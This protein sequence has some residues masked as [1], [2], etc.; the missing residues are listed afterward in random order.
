VPRIKS[1]KKSLRKSRELRLRNQATE[2]RVK[3]AVRAARAA[4]DTKP[5]EAEASVRAACRIIDRAVSKG[6]LH[7]NA[8][9]RKKSRLMRRAQK[10]AA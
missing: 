10:A 4:V 5:G 6:V 3:T 1:A 7:P 2:S 8:G 9:A